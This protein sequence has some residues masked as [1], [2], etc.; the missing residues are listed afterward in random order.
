MKFITNLRI[1]PRLGLAFATV[2]VLLLVVAAL[3]VTGLK[4]VNAGLKTVYEDRTVALGQLAELARLAQRNRVLVMDMMM[5][6]TP[7]NTTRRDKELRENFQNGQT[8]LDAYLATSLTTEEK[9]LADDFVKAR[10]IYSAAL[11]K[12]ADAMLAGN[13]EAAMS[14][15]NE[16]VSP[17]A[18]AAEKG[19]GALVRLQ[20][21]VAREEYDKAQSV[22]RLTFLISLAATALALIIG[23]GLAFTITRSITT[24]TARALALA[25]TVAAG[26]LT[27]ELEVQGQDEVSQ[28]LRA[29]G[30]MN[31]N[32]AQIVAQ[33]RNSADSIATG[34]SEIA[35]GSADLAQ[36][37][38]QQAANLEETAA[39]MDEM[40]ASVRQNADAARNAAQLAGGASKVASEGGD[41]VGQVVSTMNDISSSSKKIADIIG[42]IDAIAF[43]TNIL[44]LN[45]AV[46]AARAGE[47]GRGF[48]VVASEV[49]SLAGRS[50]QAAKEI[51]TLIGQSVEQVDAGTRLVAQAGNTMQDMVLQVQRVTELVSAIDAASGEQAKGV[52]QVAEAVNQLD[53]VTQQN[54]ALVEQS[55]AAAESLK[56]QASKLSEA[57]SVFRL[58][59]DGS[60]GMPAASPL[61]RPSYATKAPAPGHRKGAP[62][63]ATAHTAGSA[64]PS[65]DEWHS[66]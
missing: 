11:K 65:T 53:Q 54:A 48:A 51:K 37:T 23:A 27:T 38:E 1:G 40:N 64:T 16:E 8:L 31:D 30:R 43:Q 42:V 12:V 59:R 44:A 22:E 41:A 13:L 19:V 28:L 24:P 17:L 63:P 62:A 34:S 52:S 33:V 58:R 35:A 57:V 46:E 56:D 21:D 25:E 60:G 32:L 49:R 9:R 55:A 20:V 66:F 2:L 15:Y 45:A 18:P 39:S 4:R 36:R 3:G 61:R 50:A 10:S 14:A 5:R 47:Q 6:N 26:D 7:E 29:L